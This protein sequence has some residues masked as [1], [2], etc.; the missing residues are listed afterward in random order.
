MHR[1]R[2]GAGVGGAALLFVVS[3]AR[4]SP[5]EVSSPIKF[6]ST[7]CQVCSVCAARSNQALQ[8]DQELTGAP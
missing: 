8:R 3:Y 6:D 4:V 2:M 1:F 5:L 7:V